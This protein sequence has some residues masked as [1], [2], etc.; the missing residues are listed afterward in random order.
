MP[1]NFSQQL[2]DIDE[3]LRE[4][5]VS[6]Y[7]KADSIL[8]KRM[9]LELKSTLTKQRVNAT[10]SFME[11]VMKQAL[12]QTT[13]ALQEGV[14]S[15]YVLG[16]MQVD[17]ALEKED[18]VV[19]EKLSTAQREQVAALV[20]DSYLSFAKTLTVV[21]NSARSTLNEALRRQIREKI[22]TGVLL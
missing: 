5:V 4:K 19:F 12:T 6:I 3:K 18:V 11:N 15:S 10:V 21:S 22:T 17:V 20:Q 9:E 7:E 13:P 16:A 8:Q 2:G 14:Q 1:F